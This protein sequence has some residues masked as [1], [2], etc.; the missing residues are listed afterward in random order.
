MAKVKENNI[1]RKEASR[2]EKEQ[3]Q[4]Y[5]NELTAL[6]DLQNNRKKLLEESRAA[7]RQEQRNLDRESRKRKRAE[8]KGEVFDDE[9][10]FT[11]RDEMRDIVNDMV[12]DM[13]SVHVTLEDEVAAYAFNTK[14]L[15]YVDK[16]NGERTTGLALNDKGLPKLQFGE[17]GEHTGNYGLLMLM[18]NQNRSTRSAIASLSSLTKGMDPNDLEVMRRLLMLRAQDQVNNL[19][20]EAEVIARSEN[21]GTS[22]DL[23]EI[24]DKMNYTPLTSGF[25]DNLREDGYSE[26]K[27]ER[28]EKILG[29]SIKNDPTGKNCDYAYIAAN[30]RPAMK[31]LFTADEGFAHQYNAALT[32]SE[33]YQ[34]AFLQCKG[35][36]DA[37]D[38]EAD[39]VI[40]DKHKLSPE[41]DFPED[42]I[43]ER[44]Q[45]RNDMCKSNPLAD[46]SQSYMKTIDDIGK[47]QEL[48]E[49]AEKMLEESKANDIENT[50]LANRF[51]IEQ[52]GFEIGAPDASNA[53]EL[54]HKLGEESATDAQLSMS[55][56]RR[57]MDSQ[58]FDELDANAEKVFDAQ[59]DPEAYKEKYGITK[60]EALDEAAK[61]IDFGEDTTIKEIPE[62]DEAASSDGVEKEQQEFV[63]R[64]NMSADVEMK[65]T[66]DEGFRTETGE[67]VPSKP[68]KKQPQTFKEKIDEIHDR[69]MDRYTNGY[70]TNPM[71][72][73]TYNA[74]RKAIDATKSG[75]YRKR[76]LAIGEMHKQ[77]LKEA[78]YTEDINTQSFSQYMATLFK[79]IKAE[80]I[81]NGNLKFFDANQ[82]VT[83]TR[84]MSKLT[85]NKAAQAVGKAAV[86]TADAVNFARKHP[87]QAGKNVTRASATGVAFVAGKVADHFESGRYAEIAGSAIHQDKEFTEMTNTAD[88]FNEHIKHQSAETEQELDQEQLKS[89]YFGTEEEQK[90]TKSFISKNVQKQ[91]DKMNEVKASQE[92]SNAEM[93]S[94]NGSASAEDEQEL[95]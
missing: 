49:I 88:Y 60:E 90:E 22:R 1:S 87:V 71:D 43:E 33:A 66:R 26:Y 20:K 69:N 11:K 9:I 70:S 15:P 91:F 14:Y 81:A 16:A 76:F 64:S 53:Q 55:N 82:S 58:T 42:L 13:N 68:K 62:S 77:K 86:T 25:I 31:S 51:H 57:T 94:E 50:V 12:N 83:G 44:N 39:R 18:S 52:P 17:N 72:M 8:K 89:Y 23:D 74:A 35:V 40:R 48:S 3:M 37:I 84:L 36:V 56:L 73:T 7:L 63:H 46:F 6:Q 2:V 75:M 32:V 34:T 10:D 85:D 67:L 59:Q 5:E 65:P 30:F 45:L 41:D 29:D 95:E 47:A 54:A 24:R 19:D 4:V 78:G 28:F 79:N 80:L 93:E 21:F 92:A 38:K 27:L 61:D